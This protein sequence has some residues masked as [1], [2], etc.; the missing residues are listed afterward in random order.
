MKIAFLGCGYVANM[1]RLTLEMHPELELAGVY[2]H[3]RA[4]AENMAYLT[5]ARA[6]P[7]LQTLLTD[8]SVQLVLNLTNPGAHF[9]TTRALLSAGKHVYS[10]KPIALSLAETMELAD[11]AKRRG[12][13]LSSAP[14]TV[15]NPV[16][17]TL[18]QAIR[19]QRAGPIRL[20]Y[21]EMEDGMVPRAP[22]AKWVN[23][24]G[25]PWPAVDEFQTGCTL[26]HAGYVL[27]WLCAMFGPAQRVTAFSDTVLAD[28]IPGTPL[29]EAADFSTACITFQSGVIARL[30]NGL[31]APHDHRLRLFGDDGVISVDDPRSD[32]SPVRLQRYHTIRR[33][34]FL[35][36]LRKRLRPA[37]SSRPITRYRGSQVRDF[38]RAV[39]DMA[40]A[41]KTGRRPALSSD[42]G[43]HVTE[44]TLAC[45]RG[46]DHLLVTGFA[47]QEVSPWAA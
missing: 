39:A 27:S 24:A 15:L 45:H 8:D 9:Q 29:A 46:G 19:Q 2:D 17:E 31:Y 23:E 18:A 12:L 22:H 5:G 10:E 26:E 1:Y 20:V 37:R 42:F 13:M 44:L 32:T 4:R 7:D 30:T 16:A 11:L 41:I 28:K 43:V 25:T 36:P 21:A 6:Y 38:C 33:R 47:P 40:N 35:S 14:C 3:E 34:R